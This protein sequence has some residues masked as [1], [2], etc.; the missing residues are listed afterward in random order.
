MMEHTPLKNR[1]NFDNILYIGDEP[2]VCLSIIEDFNN[3]LHQI[4]QTYE[5]WFSTRRVKNMVTEY[6]R[7]QYHIH[8]HFEGGIVVFKFKDDDELP[9]YIRKECLNACGDL[10]REQLFYA[11]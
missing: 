11:S 1:I 3:R 2:K 6:D 5:D 4:E 10:A 9:F 8:Y 7:L